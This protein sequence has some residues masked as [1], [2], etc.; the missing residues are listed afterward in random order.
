MATI[1]HQ[2]GTPLQLAALFLLLVAGLTRLAIRSGRWTA[3]AA[4]TRLVVNRVFQA[5][6]AALVL[7]LLAAT[8]APLVQRM[9][10]GADQTLHGVVLTPDNQPV[11]GA[12]VTL[13]TPSVQ[14]LTNALGAFDVEIPHSRVQLTYR[15]QVSAPGF[16][17]PDL[18]TIQAAQASNMELRLQP[19]SGEIV[20]RFSPSI[21]VAQFVGVPAILLSMQIENT[22]RTIASVTEVRALLTGPRS[23]PSAIADGLDHAG[24]V[25]SLRGGQSAVTGASWSEA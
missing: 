22:G 25:W 14:V 12:T 1:L 4:T 23:V 16:R 10:Y 20:R 19:A 17:S 13:M 8:G 24:S 15:V 21:L 9:A 6:I 7:G 18:Q 2:I 5:A 3:S 11:V